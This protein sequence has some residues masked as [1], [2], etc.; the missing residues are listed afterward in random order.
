[1]EYVSPAWAP[2]LATTHDNTHQTIQNNALRI[3]TGCT[4]TTPTYHLHYETQVLTLQDHINMR[5]TQF[6]AAISANPDHPC[7]YMLVHQ[8]TPHSIKTT[9][10]ALYTGLNTIPQHSS[11]HIHTHFTNIAIQKL[12]PNTILGTPPPEI[13]YSEHALPRADRVHL[14]RLRCGHH[15]ELATYR[16]R[17]DDSV[18]E[19]CRHCS[20]NTHSLTHIM[21]HC[22]ALTYIRVQHNISSPLDQWHSPANRLLLFRG[23]GLLGQTS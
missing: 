16:K 1:M 7:H 19:V 22:P 6:L 3:V 8:P 10:Q 4:Q 13:H 9:P 20:T 18:D 12:G 11:S 15:T 21:T 5:G 17:I 14:S 2:N 23:A